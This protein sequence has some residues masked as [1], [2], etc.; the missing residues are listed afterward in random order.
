VVVQ[1][2]LGDG[3]FAPPT[4][5]AIPND[6]SGTGRLVAGDFDGDGR[7][8]L[9]VVFFNDFLSPDALRRQWNWAVFLNQGD[10][11]FA[12]GGTGGLGA[13]S[14]GDLIDS[15]YAADLNNDG[16]LDL[17]AALSSH[18]EALL[19][20][21]DGTFS[22]PVEGPLSTDLANIAQPTALADFD[23][24]GYLDLAVLE[25]GGVSVFRGKGDGTF[26]ATQTVAVSAPTL[27]G[28]A[29]DG[30]TAADLNGDGRPDLA[31]TL[32]I[33]TL[34]VP[35]SSVAVLLHRGDGTFDAPGPV[36]DA[37]GGVQLVAADLNGDGHFD[38]IAG[39]G[40]N[41][42]RSSRGGIPAAEVLLGRGDGTFASP[43][44]YGL[45]VTSVNAETQ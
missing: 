36:F 2:G 40:F 11:T 44:A 8:D 3:T 9:A 12:A 30:L 18:T 21:G 29:E 13:A 41:G 43:V 1:Y 10:G 23:G 19:G 33:G 42:N 22:G 31:L 28:A 25:A 45:D 37:A 4:S 15:L 32:A 27:P 17:L 7:T 20:A 26:T 16:H 14:S 24:D 35:Q 5:F 38:L 34:S 39:G 6:R